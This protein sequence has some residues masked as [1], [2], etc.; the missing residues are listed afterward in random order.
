MLTRV[1]FIDMSLVCIF[2]DMGDKVDPGDFLLKDREARWN[3]GW[4]KGFELRLS[5]DN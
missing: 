5:F 2:P 4:I 1:R 3:G